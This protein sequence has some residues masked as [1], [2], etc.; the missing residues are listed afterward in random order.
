[1][2]IKLSRNKREGWYVFHHGRKAYRGG[3]KL[4]S[5]RHRNNKQMHSRSVSIYHRG[6]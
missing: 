5:M 4:D 2:K 6:E 3:A 1:M